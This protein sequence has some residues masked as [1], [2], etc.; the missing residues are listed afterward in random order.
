MM[1]EIVLIF[2]MCGVDLIF[3]YLAYLGIRDYLKY[4][5]EKD[6]AIPFVESIISEHPKDS[7]ER[8]NLLINSGFSK[9]TIRKILN[10][11][12]VKKN[13]RKE[14]AKLPKKESGRNRKKKTRRTR[15]RYF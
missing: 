15:E 12:V 2:V 14:S 1:L 13:D 9:S 10:N 5:E 4:K 6:K 11:K 3:Y 8:N 7:E